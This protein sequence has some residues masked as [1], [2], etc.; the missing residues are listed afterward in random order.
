MKLSVSLSDDDVA[1]LDEYAR[2]AG[3]KGRSAV[4]QHALRLLR[5]AVLEEDYAAAWEEWESIG[6][7]S[8]WDV[9]AGDGL[10]DAPR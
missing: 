8:V 3:L 1:L 5:Q 4:I 6:E 10:V 7:Q 2:T 9:T